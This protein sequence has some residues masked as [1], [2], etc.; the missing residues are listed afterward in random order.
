M[1]FNQLPMIYNV[2]K[3]RLYRNNRLIAEKWVGGHSILW[4]FQE[5]EYTKMYLTYL[6]D[7]MSIVIEGA[8]SEIIVLE[9]ILK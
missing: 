4:Y 3:I 7:N 5:D 8:L 6:I 2:D 1:R 9:I